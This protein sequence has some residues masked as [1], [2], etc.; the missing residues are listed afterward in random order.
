MSSDLNPILWAA[1]TLHDKVQPYGY[2]RPD[3]AQIQSML[4]NFDDPEVHSVK[5]GVIS[6]N[7]LDDDIEVSFALR[8]GDIAF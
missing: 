6:M 2:K 7:R 1:E 3:I 8:V 4:K 5:S